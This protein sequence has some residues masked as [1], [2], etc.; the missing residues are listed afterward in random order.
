MGALQ[1]PSRESGTRKTWGMVEGTDAGS[2]TQSETYRPP[3]D[4]KFVSEPTAAEA[5][6]GKEA[7]RATE[8]EEIR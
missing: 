1:G 5:T 3:E 4:N 7:L 8:I 6:R 2:R